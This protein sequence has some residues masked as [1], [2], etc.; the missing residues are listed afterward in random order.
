MSPPGTTPPPRQSARPGGVQ[1]SRGKGVLLLTFGDGTGQP[2]AW[3]ARDQGSCPRNVRSAD[4]RK[5]LAAAAK[6]LCG[7]GNSLAGGPPCPGPGWPGSCPALPCTDGRCVL[8]TSSPVRLQRSG[9]AW[10]QRGGSTRAGA[11][12]SGVQGKGAETF[13]T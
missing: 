2:I 8:A 7:R 4:A 11:R 9:R 13:G 1:F 5:L 10:G 12:G 6:R 3:A